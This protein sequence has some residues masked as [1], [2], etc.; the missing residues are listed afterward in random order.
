MN[1]SAVLQL[2]STPVNA[3][4]RPY[5]F[6]NREYLNETRDMLLGNALRETTIGLDK[7]ELIRL[8]AHA[9]SASKRT[10]GLRM[11]AGSKLC[12]IRRMRFILAGSSRSRK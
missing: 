8:L 3:P 4:T 6:T 10:S 1:R 11:P 7:P 9:S 5:R 2:R 12:L